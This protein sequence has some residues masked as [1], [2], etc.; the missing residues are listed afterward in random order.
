VSRTHGPNGDVPHVEVQ[1]EAGG[2]F[3]PPSVRVPLDVSPLL[4]GRV[5]PKRYFATLNKCNQIL[6]ENGIGSCNWACLLCPCVGL[7]YASQ[8]NEE[9]ERL[10][11]A[12]LAGE[13]NHIYGELGMHWHIMVESHT[14]KNEQGHQQTV[15]FRK[16]LQLDVIPAREEARAAEELKQQVQAQAAQLNHLHSQMMMQREEPAAAAAKRVEI[17]VPAGGPF[18]V[19]NFGEL[20]IVREIGSGSF[21][22]VFSARWRGSDVVVKK[23]RAELAT[24]AVVGDFLAEAQLCERVCRHP[25]VVRFIGATTKLPDLC[26]VFEYLPNGS[27]E[28]V[29]FRQKRF[30]SV[31][32]LPRL[33]QIAEDCAAGVLHLHEESVVHRDIAARNV[34][35]D[36][37]FRARVSDFGMSRVKES[38]DRDAP[39]HTASVVGPLKWFGPPRMRLRARHAHLA[40]PPPLVLPCAGWPLS[41]SRG[42][43]TRPS[44]TSG[45]LASSSLKCAYPSPPMRAALINARRRSLFLLAPALRS[46]FAD[47]RGLALTTWKPPYECARARRC[48]SLIRYP[49]R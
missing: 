20:Q 36:E 46:L 32:D 39:E 8:R 45:C 19:L 38:E 29:L 25:N 35:L 43:S 18:Q 42:R 3:A 10:L 41:R 30:A 33:V 12:Y 16:W 7:C 15:F 48:T 1:F 24:A 2:L 28:N 11:K 47:L 49:S 17:V 40:R 4:R 26:L 21:G 31:A 9:A 13:N 5:D 37:L 22:T 44:P 27:L 6:Q 23:L 14:M 34:L